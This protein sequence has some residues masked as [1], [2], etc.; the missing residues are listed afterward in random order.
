VSTAL[1]T[2]GS[3]G[4]RAGGARQRASLRWNSVASRDGGPSDRHR[5]GGRCYPSLAGRLLA[6]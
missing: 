6:L 1:K 3:T 2:L 4:L 5:H